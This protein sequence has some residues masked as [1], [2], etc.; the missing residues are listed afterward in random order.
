MLN[1][2][3][4]P[5]ERCGDYT[6]YTGFGGD[7]MR[8]LRCITGTETN[9]VWEAKTVEHLRK[10]LDDLGAPILNAMIAGCSRAFRPDIR[11]YAA[12]VDRHIIIEVDERSHAGYDQDDE[13]DRM[14]EIAEVL[15]G[16]VT[17]LRFDPVP[18]RAFPALL[19]ERLLVLVSAVRTAASEQRSDTVVRYLFYN[20]RPVPTATDDDEDSDD[21]L[22][23]E[24]FVMQ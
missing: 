15:G 21:D 24:D 11:Y 6:V 10:A 8:C 4:P 14:A 2:K 3:N 16:R 13:R 22:L 1:L 19:E 7:K 5:C 9:R 17:F 12:E 20:Y 23:L 18:S